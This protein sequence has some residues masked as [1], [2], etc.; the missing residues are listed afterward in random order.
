MAEP[1]NAARIE[2]DA[3][4]Y[5]DAKYMAA[6][7]SSPGYQQDMRDYLQ[8]ISSIALL[9]NIMEKRS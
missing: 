2:A 8:T 1:I 7:P 4:T 9:D 6:H 5:A 3:R